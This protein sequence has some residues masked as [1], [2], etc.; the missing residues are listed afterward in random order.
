MP[1][2]PRCPRCLGFPPD[3]KW[4]SRGT[5]WSGS[6]GQELSRDSFKVGFAGLNILA[7]RAGPRPGPTRWR[8][9]AKLGRTSANNMML[10]L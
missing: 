4:A 8:S 9:G 1:V 3:P 5:R 2:E 6:S 10:T 7:N